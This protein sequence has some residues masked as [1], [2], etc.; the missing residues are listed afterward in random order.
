MHT[1]KNEVND[2]CRIEGEQAMCKIQFREYDQ[3]GLWVQPKTHGDTVD[4]I[5]KNMTEDIMKLQ[6][7]ILYKGGH[8]FT[9]TA[10]CYGEGYNMLSQYA[11]T[12]EEIHLIGSYGDYQHYKLPMEEGWNQVYNMMIV[13]LGEPNAV[14][15]GFTS[16]QRFT[17]MFRF[18]EKELKI[19]LNGEGVEI[20]PGETMELEQL[21]VASGE[22]Q[23]LLKRFGEAIKK[24]HPPLET[25]EVPTGWCSWL[26]YGP[27]VA[28]EDIYKNLDA[29]QE[30]NLPLTYIQ[31]DDGYQ[32]HMGDWLSVTEKFQGGMETLCRHI[33]EE[34]F[35]PAVWVAPFIADGE[36]RIFA[37]HPEWFV[38]DEEGKPLPSDRC[39]FGGWRCGPWYMLDGTHPEARSYLTHVFQ[40]MREEWHVKYFKLDA[41]MWGA[42]P[43]GFRY[44][45]NKT[46]VEAYRM[47]MEA[48]LKGAGK[49]SFL[50]GCNAPMWPSIGTVHGMRISDDNARNMD[51]FIKLAGECFHRNWQHRVLWI[52]D[53]DVVLQQNRD[54]I[55][56]DPAGKKTTT[57]GTQLT[58]NEFLF[59]AAYVMASG[60]MILS[61][62]DISTLTPVNEER[63]KKM[64]PPTDVA[65]IF[66][67]SYEIGRA[68]LGEEREYIYLFN[69]GNEEKTMDV[70]LTGDSRVTDFWTEESLIVKDNRIS[71]TLSPRSACIL[72]SSCE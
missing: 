21:F 34:G 20:Q 27:N 16:C 46:C 15:M 11:G 18:N 64:L 45:K 36:S 10:H 66:N 17:G 40:V 30:K 70:E 65:A 41:N 47:G 9:E 54:L 42:M 39:S 67:E 1:L 26:V 60:G 53:P 35:E 37:E 69:Y 31:I 68:K 58:E 14:L 48:I 59:C 51:R 38:K 8:E 63:L 2:K 32:P 52:N 19:M 61:G 7:I 29:I 25:K 71:V 12:I 72:Y 13:S 50:L 49:D 23:E 6:D 62:D 5:I 44:E 33:K 43:F 24:N 56:L 55:V 4:F 22:K 28:E 57:K 3:D